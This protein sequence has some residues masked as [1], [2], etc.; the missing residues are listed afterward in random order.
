MFDIGWTE[1]LLIGI[2]ALIVVGPNDLPGMFRALG[3]FT[4]QI[5]SMARDFQR[6]MNEAADETGMRDVASDLRSMTSPRAM[7][8]DA[9]RDLSSLES[10]DMPN[11]EKAESADSKKLSEARAE[12]KRKIEEH[13]ARTAQSRLDAEAKAAEAEKAGATPKAAPASGKAGAKSASKTATPARKSAKK[14][15]ARGKTA[16]AGAGT[17]AAK[18]P[19]AKKRAATKADDAS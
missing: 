13:S 7:G 9:L 15:A 6:S 3:R 12:A 18:K 5:R 14:P 17:N 1:L 4:A 11:E 16:G 8:M 10:N 19:A 2:V